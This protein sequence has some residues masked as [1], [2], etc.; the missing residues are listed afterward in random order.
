[1]SQCLFFS[2]RETEKV[3]HAH[4]TKWLLKF[5]SF[6]QDFY[7]KDVVLYIQNVCMPLLLSV[8]SVD[9]LH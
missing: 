8:N 5:Y 1:M 4:G 3:S 9:T 2:E 7:V 6:C